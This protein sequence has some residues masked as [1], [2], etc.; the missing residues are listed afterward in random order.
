M[1]N[2][3]RRETLRRREKI[4]KQRVEENGEKGV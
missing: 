2:G 4:V 1:V 3:N